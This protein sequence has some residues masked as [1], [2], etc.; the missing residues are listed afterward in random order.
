MV[1]LR[2]P[3][4]FFFFRLFLFLWV[5]TAFCFNTSIPLH[6]WRV[7]SPLVSLCVSV[8]YLYTRCSGQRPAW[9]ERETSPVWCRHKRRKENGVESTS[10][11][12][13]LWSNLYVMGSFTNRAHYKLLCKAPTQPLKCMPLYQRFNQWFTCICLFHLQILLIHVIWF[14][15]TFCVF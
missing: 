13:W 8:L 4:S 11:D 6:R 14:R 1:P 10:R 9:K 2:H 7:I 12:P 15:F 3:G 5:G